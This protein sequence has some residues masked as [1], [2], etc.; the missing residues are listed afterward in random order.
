ME[1]CPEHKNMDENVK[2]LKEVVKVF[3]E[4]KI[5]ED[6]K[7][8]Y[9]KKFME[10]LK[11]DNKEIKEELKKINLC[12]SEN[13]VKKAKSDQL[14]Q[15]IDEVNRDLNSKLIAQ[16]DELRSYFIKMISISI[17]GAGLIFGIMQWVIQVR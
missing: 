7:N 1:K 5:E 14:E 16:N 10:E 17:S 6:T 8:N 9:Q 2:A 3:S 11:E 12:L 15:K 13:Y 4:W